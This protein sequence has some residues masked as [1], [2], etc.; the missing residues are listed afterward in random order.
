MNYRKYVIIC[1]NLIIAIW[2]YDTIF[3]PKFDTDFFGLFLILVFGFWFFYNIYAF[4]IYKYYFINIQ[5]KPIL[6]ILFVLLLLLP[7]FMVWY[8]TT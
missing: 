6:E 2:L 8:F 7:F 4:L 3:Y 5:S 1:I